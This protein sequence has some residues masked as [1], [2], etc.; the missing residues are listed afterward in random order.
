MGVEG[1][2]FHN[3]VHITILGGLV[4]LPQPRAQGGDVISPHVC[5][6]APK[7]T[8]KRAVNVRMYCH[9]FTLVKRHD[10]RFVED[11]LKFKSLLSHLISC[12]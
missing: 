3:D 4:Q 11:I 7:N 12:Y 8:S 9:H 6:I 2:L 5:P 10:I 1:P